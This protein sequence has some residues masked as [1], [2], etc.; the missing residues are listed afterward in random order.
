MFI[1]KFALLWKVSQIL[2]NFKD[3]WST[4]NIFP[5][6]FT[7]FPPKESCCFLFCSSHIFIFWS[8][9]L[10]NFLSVFFCLAHL[11]L[12]NVNKD[13]VIFSYFCNFI[14]KSDQNQIWKMER[15]LLRCDLGTFHIT[16]CWPERTF[17]VSFGADSSIGKAIKPRL[18]L[19]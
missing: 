9:Y 4:M 2:S 18:L 14:T 7:N 8:L 19:S 5:S 3:L 16:H 12:Q 1:M 17:A 11:A 13:Y 10:R 6:S 15:S